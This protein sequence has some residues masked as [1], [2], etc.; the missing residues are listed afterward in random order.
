[1]EKRGCDGDGGQLRW[2]L[3]LVVDSGGGSGCGGCGGAG[4]GSGGGDGG[5]IYVKLCHNAWYT[6]KS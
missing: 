6:H 4:G 5:A 1:M 2:R 3:L